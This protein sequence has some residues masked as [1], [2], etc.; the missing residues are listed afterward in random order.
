M[1]N[2]ICGRAL[3][4]INAEINAQ[5]VLNVLN[6]CLKVQ[7][8]TFVKCVSDHRALEEREREKAALNALSARLKID[9]PPMD[10]HLQWAER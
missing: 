3:E 6:N 1:R 7:K 2:N 10:F 8:V 5:Q 4:V 9:R